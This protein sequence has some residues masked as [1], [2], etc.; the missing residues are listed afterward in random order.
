MR[1]GDG[2]VGS[3]REL[4]CQAGYRSP[5]NGR[6]VVMEVEFACIVIG[7]DAGMRNGRRAIRHR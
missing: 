6:Y 1:Y 2:C 5:R 3:D 7:E 4:S